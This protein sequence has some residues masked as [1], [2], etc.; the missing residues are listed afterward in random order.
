MSS[1]GLFYE[2]NPNM[3]AVINSKPINNL[4]SVN[5]LNTLSANSPGSSSTLSA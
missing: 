3:G 1:K 2:E 4:L 5:I